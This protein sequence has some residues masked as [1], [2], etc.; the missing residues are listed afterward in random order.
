MIGKSETAKR[1]VTSAEA[2]EIL[3]K[4]KEDDKLGYEQELAHDHIAKYGGASAAEGRKMKKELMELG[5]TEAT[6]IKI[7]DIMPID[8]AQLKHILVLEK[9]NYDEEDIKKMMEIVEGHKGK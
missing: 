1:P 5:V 2:L 8:V 4:R 7:A 9:K 6:A 3:E